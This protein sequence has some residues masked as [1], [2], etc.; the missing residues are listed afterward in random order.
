MQAALAVPTSPVPCDSDLQ[1]RTHGILEL[2][3]W[4]SRSC[5]L[6]KTRGNVGLPG[7]T[8]APDLPAR[9]CVQSK[10]PQPGSPAHP[11]VHQGVTDEVTPSQG[12]EQSVFLMLPNSLPQ[13]ASPVPPLND[14]GPWGRGGRP[15]DL[16]SGGARVRGTQSLGLA[17]SL[18]GPGSAAPVGPSPRFASQGESVEATGALRWWHVPS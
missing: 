10:I 1:L 3:A 12:R 4:A 17:R 8:R 9:N 2:T 13:P 5:S 6:P 7:A 16:P 11:V 14:R 18:V 15:A